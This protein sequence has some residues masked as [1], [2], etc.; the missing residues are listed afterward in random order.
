MELLDMRYFVEVAHCSSVTRAAERLYLTQPT[1]SRRIKHFEQELGVQL[2][3]RDPQSVHLTDAGAALLPEAEKILASCDAVPALLA[4]F[5]ARTANGIAGTLKIA[6]QSL[7][8]SRQLLNI[9][10]A[11]PQRYPNAQVEPVT[12]DTERIPQALQRSEID[13]ALIVANRFYHLDNTGFQKI[14]TERFNLLAPASSPFATRESVDIKE[15]EGIDVVLFDREVAPG[16]YDAITTQCIIN[17][18]MLNHRYREN[19]SDNLLLTVQTG[20][21]HSFILSCS[22][23]MPELRERGLVAV[24]LTGADLE[25]DLGV[26]YRANDTR[27]ILRALIDIV[28]EMA[29]P[30]EAASDEEGTDE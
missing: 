11:M 27:P 18:F 3:V 10:Q 2:F 13:A 24:K 1:L 14:S 19:N 22:K 29:A 20:K 8:D 5:A 25:N 26:V 21:A 28:A 6:S 15:L 30:Y 23:H 12:L 4:P 16:Y 9:A 17:G 7:I